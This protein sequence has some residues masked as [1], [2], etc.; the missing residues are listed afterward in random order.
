MKRIGVFAAIVLAG[1]WAAIAAPAQ[2]DMSQRGHGEM[3]MRQA[4]GVK[5]SVQDDAARH[6]LTVRVGP[7]DLPAHA[8]HPE[9]AQAPNQVLTIPFDGWITA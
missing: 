9:A 2:H 6:L 8:T 1:S 7:L 5:L 4:A 3:K